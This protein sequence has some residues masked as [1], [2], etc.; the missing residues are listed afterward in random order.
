LPGFLKRE[1]VEAATLKEE[2]K[3]IASSVFEKFNKKM[4]WVPAIPKA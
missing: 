2:N 4:E 1:L 3:N